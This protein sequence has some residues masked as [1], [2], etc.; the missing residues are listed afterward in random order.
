MNDIPPA[1]STVLSNEMK[2]PEGHSLPNQTANG[3][4]TP[5]YCAYPRKRRT[6]AVVG[7]LA[8]R[9]SGMKSERKDLKQLETRRVEFAVDRFEAR[10]EFLKPP[11]GLTG[12]QAESYVTK[13]LVDLTPYALAEMEFQLKFGD[14]KA[15]TEMARDILDR[16]G[17]GK[18]EV[19]A[20]YQGPVL[21][22]T[23][24]SGKIE[25]PWL[26][27][28]PADPPQQLVLTPAKSE[29]SIEPVVASEPVPTK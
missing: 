27:R 22:I 6:R 3:D 14:D 23:A 21:M 11:E 4:C 25:L 26:Q 18:K 19:G 20:V 29:D 7:D 9:S 12:P 10:R 1:V 13:K 5:V 28:A 2:C 17:F 8:K 15:R 24:P 16:A